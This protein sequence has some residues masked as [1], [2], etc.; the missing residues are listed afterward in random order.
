MSDRDPLEL[1][2]LVA[3]TAA[4]YAQNGTRLPGGIAF[5][6]EYQRFDGKS[7]TVAVATATRLG[8]ILRDLLPEE[9][10]IDPARNE[11]A[12]AICRAVLELARVDTTLH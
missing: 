7:I 3:R 8:E 6:C 12:L 9:F 2:S 1:R 5:V 10:A 11:D 4:F